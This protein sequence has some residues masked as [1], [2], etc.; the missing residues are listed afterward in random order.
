M[1]VPMLTVEGTTWRTGAQAVDCNRLASYSHSV[2]RLLA[3]RS[4]VAYLASQTQFLG[5]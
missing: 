3:V 2:A 1:A 5:L 4:W